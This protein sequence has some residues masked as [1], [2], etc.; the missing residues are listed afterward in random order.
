MLKDWPKEVLE[1]GNDFQKA[2]SEQEHQ[3][4]QQEQNAVNT[5]G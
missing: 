4:P 3:G 2:I 5:I 1:T